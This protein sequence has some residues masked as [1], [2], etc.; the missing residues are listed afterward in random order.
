MEALDFNLI[1]F[2]QDPTFV[3]RRIAGEC[4]LVPIRQ[5]VADLQYIYVLNPVANRIWE[6]LDGQRTLA[7]VRD[8]L[9]E[10]FEVSS[11]ELE[12]DLHEFIAQLRQ[13]EAIR[14]I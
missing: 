14:E 6:L 3:Y 5:Q 10:E 7:E 8:R 2:S 12:Q 13:I 4:L 1:R 11:E 9:L